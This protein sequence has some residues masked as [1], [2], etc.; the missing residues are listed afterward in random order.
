MKN[1]HDWHVAAEPDYDG[2]G[3]YY[4]SIG[5]DPTGPACHECEAPCPQI[6]NGITWAPALRFSTPEGDEWYACSE[7]CY[8]KMIAGWEAA[9][10]HRENAVIFNRA[11]DEEIAEAAL[12]C[13]TCEWCEN[14]QAY[15]ESCPAC[16]QQG[17]DADG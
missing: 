14:R 13:A 8:A 17:P 6:W 3:D 4:D 11:S 2:A 5:F 15:C 16:W 1:A 7:A 10:V 12:F 9:Q